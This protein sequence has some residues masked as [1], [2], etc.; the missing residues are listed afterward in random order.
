M[1]DQRY[2]FGCTVS[3]ECPI[4]A[5]TSAEKSVYEARLPD[6]E[7]VARA[8]ARQVF[9]CQLCGAALTERPRLMIQVVPAG[10]E[11][12]RSRGFVLR[13]AA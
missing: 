3:F 12:L 13:P 11:Q 5:R 1:T 10:R 9:D 8:V 4:C 2:Y 6:A 7:R